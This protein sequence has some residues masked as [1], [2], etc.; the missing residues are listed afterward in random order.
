[1][2][3]QIEVLGK[4]VA[5]DGEKWTSEDPAAAELCQLTAEMLPPDYYPD[6]VG[7]LAAAVAAELQGRV[8][9]R[10]PVEDDGEPEDTIY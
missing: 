1:M 3:A 8:V 10:D 4:L 9:K 6:P 2:A 5:Y 7:D